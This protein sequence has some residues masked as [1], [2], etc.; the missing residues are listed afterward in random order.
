VGTLWLL[1]QPQLS[2][3]D[4]SAGGVL[5]VA[6]IV[7]GV[8]RAAWESYK[9]DAGPRHFAWLLFC[10]RV[11]REPASLLEIAHQTLAHLNGVDAIPQLFGEVLDRRKADR[12]A[13]LNRRL[14]DVN[15]PAK[16][17]AKL[18]SYTTAEG[19]GLGRIVKAYASIDAATRSITSQRDYAANFAKLLREEPTLR[20]AS[21]L[22]SLWAAIDASLRTTSTESI[23]SLA[24]DVEKAHKLLGQSFRPE[25]GDVLKEAL[26]AISFL[27]RYSLAD[28]LDVRVA[29]LTKALVSLERAESL[30]SASTP[31]ESLFLVAVMQHWR[32]AARLELE[33]L[34]STAHLRLT[35]ESREA[36]RE[37]RTTLLAHLLN[38]GRGF[39]EDLVVSLQPSD[40]YTTTAD[41][42][43]PATFDL[44]AS[45]TKKTIRFQLAIGAAD[46]FVIVVRVTYK[47]A[48]GKREES[49]REQIVVV[50]RG[51]SFADL[52]N[53]YTSTVGQAIRVRGSKVFFGRS[54]VFRQ[55]VQVL[56]ESSHE[57]G[58]KAVVLL[59]GE[60]R[61]GKTT[62]LLQLDYE[63]PS[64]YLPVFS[65][66][67]G[68]NDAGDA[69]FLHWL[70]FQIELGLQKHSVK[71][72]PPRLETLQAA[73][74]TL[75]S[76]FVNRELKNSLGGR[77]LV[78][79]FDEFEH[80][81]DLI[82]EGKQSK[83][84]LLFL[85]DLMQHG[86]NVSFVFAGTHLLREFAS[87]YQSIMFNIAHTL[88]LGHL[89]ESDTRRLV[90]EPVQGMLQYDTDAQNYVYRL[91]RGHPY[92]TQLMCYEIVKQQKQLQ[93]SYTTVSDVEDAARRVLD[94]G[95]SH[96][97]YIF[98]VLS[99]I[100]RLVLAG[101]S[102]WTEGGRSF[103][104]SDVVDN[105]R[106]YDITL[107]L[108]EAQRIVDAFAQRELLV[109][110]QSNVHSGEYSFGM[111]VVRR[112]LA[113]YRPFSQVLNQELQSI[114]VN[115]RL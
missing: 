92:F 28:T 24:S 54:D 63:L 108:L 113:R 110:Q 76:A 73:P 67:Q 72:D 4:F 13:F 42:V 82:R 70:G 86:P 93:K 102:T 51:H 44:L 106:R 74:T 38:E 105:L 83:G 81:Q 89:S 2:F 26:Q 7:I 45:N 56:Q 12:L 50:E 20:G 91:T 62:V 78:L 37:D 16:V 1:F 6:V 101:T 75:F 100:E 60:R 65:D 36:V 52:P 80:M 25:L 104:V 53:P 107:P 14:Y 90:V 46:Q 34:Q 32:H 103:L 69:A 114:N 41:P 112:W 15:D 18:A 79:L 29:F 40:G 27:R 97:S 68:F 84:I 88:K 57:P 111:E 47:D 85:R 96:F 23:L 95:S 5:T 61:M 19:A 35:F 10:G 55:I 64:Q 59:V 71:V 115:R 11:Q 33:Q 49:F 43:Q 9:G 99:P 77:G 39:A 98:D 3:R 87:E 30:S 8:L 17:L 58:G 48:R 66:L 21:A 109:Q 22:G 94:A 31:P